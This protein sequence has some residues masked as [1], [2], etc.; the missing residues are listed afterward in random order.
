MD[1]SGSAF[2]HVEG[3]GDEHSIRGG[4]TKREWFAGMALCGL[5]ASSWRESKSTER[6]YAETALI[7]ADAMLA[8]S[9]EG[10]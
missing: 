10:K 2:G 6:D 4:L 5:L 7:I 3:H 8:Q 9:G 1:K